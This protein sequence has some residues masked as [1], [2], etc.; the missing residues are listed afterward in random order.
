M[1]DGKRNYT[2]EN[3]DYLRRQILCEL[4]GLTDDELEAYIKLISAL[5]R[6]ESQSLALNPRQEVTT[7]PYGPR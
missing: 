4:E 2:K 6:G 7:A 3:A 1:N 5:R